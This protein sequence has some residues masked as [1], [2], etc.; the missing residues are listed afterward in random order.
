VN[1]EEGIVN[2]V[3]N[4]R[5]VPLNADPKGHGVGTVPPIECL[6]GGGLTRAS[7]GDQFLIVSL[8]QGRC[9][10]KGGAL[11][12]RCLWLTRRAQALGDTPRLRN[13]S[14]LRNIPVHV[15]IAQGPTE[16][17]PTRLRK[18]SAIL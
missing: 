8:F 10:T 13:T 4:I 7:Q 12:R 15:L 6:K 2:D 3:L 18:E 14:R 9:R 5:G 11:L 1:P 17:R 16:L